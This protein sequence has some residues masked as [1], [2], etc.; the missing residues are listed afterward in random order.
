LDTTLL[1][2]EGYGDIFLAKLETNGNVLWAK[3]AGGANGDWGSS[4][5]VGPSGDVYL[6]GNFQSANI[7]F[8]S[9]TLYN[10]GGLNINYD[11]F[12]A[13]FDSFGNSLWARSVGGIGNDR[14]VE[15][16]L[17]AMENSY[18]L[19][20][21]D[22]STIV[23]NSNTFLNAGEE[24]VFLSKYD[25][26]G[27]VLWAKSAG[28]TDY[29]SPRSIA[30]DGLGNIFIAGSFYSPSLTFGSTTLLNSGSWDIFFTKL[31]YN[32]V[33]N[34][35]ALY[36]ITPD[37]LIPHNY[38]I[39]SNSTGI[40]PFDY[41]WSWGDGTTDTTAL[42]SHTYSTAGYY[43]IC[44]TITDSVGCSS[45]FCDS[46][47]LS[48]NSDAMV[49]VNVILQTGITENSVN[50]SL[51]FYPNPATASLTIQT[52]TKAIIEIHNLQ[53]QLLK[54]INTAEKQTT[55]DVSDFAN[56]IYI[57]KAKTD[58]GVAVKKFIKD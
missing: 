32:I 26:N 23:I 22:S 57:I 48:K 54:T 2:S 33:T 39:I 16:A 5:K 27:N 58:R 29:D 30:V 51:L 38:F 19:V 35:S 9:N 50:E 31:G 47:F 1:T 7:N 49:Y 21:F 44:L 56:G 17:D 13:K 52:P 40:P 3:S 34:C 8:D 45:T 55:I 11:A 41:L 28:G 42:P 12:L 4:V 10:V 36:T 15:I 18:M 37:T 43:N 53:G 24:D 25:I 6:G 46:S 20:G 14:T